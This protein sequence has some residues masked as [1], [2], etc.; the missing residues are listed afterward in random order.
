MRL[1]IKCY[2][3]YLGYDDI[4]GEVH[5]NRELSALERFNF[6][7]YMYEMEANEII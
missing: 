2:P 3:N 7:E 5:I 1:N 6:L 4:D